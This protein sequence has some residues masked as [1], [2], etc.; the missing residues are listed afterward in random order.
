MTQTVNIDSVTQTVN[1]DSNNKII[2]CTQTVNFNLSLNSNI[3]T[4][5]SIQNQLTQTTKNTKESHDL[6]GNNLNHRI[7]AN[8]VP[9]EDSFGS[10]AEKTGQNNTKNGANEASDKNTGTEKECHT[11]SEVTED[12]LNIK[13]YEGL[14]KC[15]SDDKSLAIKSHEDKMDKNDRINVSTVN[16]Y[17]LYSQAHCTRTVHDQI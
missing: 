5:N 14:D 4:V 17:V 6:G 9:K 1:P 11:V 3:Q 2:E 8:S 15:E 16:N 13:G 10:K 12:V 7:M